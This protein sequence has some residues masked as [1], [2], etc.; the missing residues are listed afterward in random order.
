MNGSRLF[1]L[2]LLLIVI[3]GFQEVNANDAPRTSDVQNALH[4]A[5]GFFLNDVSTEG[6]YL[7]Q[8][9]ADLSLREG[10]GVA[11]AHTVWVQPPGT[12]SVG[13]AYLEAYQLTGDP[14]LL[15]AAKQA[16]YALVRGQLRSGGLA[17]QIHFDAKGR[18]RYAYRVDQDES[19]RRNT[20]TLDDN[21]TQSALRL[22]MRMD[23]QLKFQNSKIHEAAQFGLASLLDAQ[24]PNGAWPQRYTEPPDP[25]GFPVM[26]A[27]YPKVWSRKY[28]KPRY[29]SYYTFNDNTIADMIT[30][31]LQAASTYDSKRYQ[32]AAEKAG[33]F[34]L[35]AQ[36]PDPQPAWAQQ[37]DSEMQPAWA[38]R[39]EPP[40]I[41]GGESQG[42]LRVLMTLYR[43]TG[44]KKYIQSI[45][46]ALTYLKRSRLPDGQLARF[47]ELK[48]NRP[49][50]FTRQYELTY[51]SND[52]PTHYA[53][54]VGSGLDRIEKTY[55]QLARTTW[56]PPKDRTELSIGRMTS[57]LA[58]QTRTLIDRMDDR[59]A[60]VEPGKLKYHKNATTT[61]VIRCSTFAKNIVTLSRYLAASK[62]T[63]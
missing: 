26:S 33:D 28:P 20:T 47:Y 22:L 44:K 52:M 15:D 11:D 10:E 41:T 31:M 51:E 48:T 63:E 58:Q 25:A 27:S 23:R 61:T 8:Y 55:H 54:I 45:P 29:S 17:Y 30:T 39:F 21:T 4:K 40:A 42:V 12:P 32:A 46:R 18:R 16:A 2:G 7:W 53:F 3:A 56:K 62:A 13:Q 49:L 60:W 43:A 59:G 5:I 36:M 38:R 50:Y 34:I 19:G 57:R 37:Y 6:G 14:A 24:Y 9:S 1:T 35:L